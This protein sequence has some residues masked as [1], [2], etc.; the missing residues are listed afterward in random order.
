M[1][2][3]GGATI[4]V[5][6]DVPEKVRLLEAATARSPAPR[7]GGCLVICLG[8]YVAPCQARDDLLEAPRPTR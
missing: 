1:S 6:D 7:S 4:L 8:Y 2:G 3:D 5:V